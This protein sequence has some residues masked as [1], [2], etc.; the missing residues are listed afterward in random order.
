V[1]RDLRFRHLTRHFFDGLFDFGFLSDAGVRS[2]V[3]TILGIFA[4][5]AGF[6]LLLTR[7]FMKRYGSFAGADS[8]EPY[9]QAIVADHAFLIAIPMWIVAFVTTLV[10]YAL[11]PDETDF[12]ILM[13]LPLTR[14]IVFA[15]KLAAVALFTG[16]FVVAT[17]LALSPL[18]LLSSF[19][20]WAQRSWPVGAAAYLSASLIGSM[21]AL[22]LVV[23]IHGVLVLL[24]IRG[25][26]VAASALVRSGML[27]ALVLALPFLLRLPMQASR[28]ADGASFLSFIPPAWF[29]G[30]EHTLAGDATPF[31]SGLSTIAVVATALVT[32]IAVTSY[33]MLYRHF[34]RVMVRPALSQA[35]SLR[36]DRRALS[37][38]HLSG[39]PIF[40]AIR[41]FVAITLRRS[42]FHQG[43]VV[44]ISALGGGLVLNSF[45][46]ADLFGWMGTGGPPSQRLRDAVIWAPLAL[47]FVACFAVRASLRVPRELRANWVFRM[48]EKETARTDQLGPATQTMRL[49]GV[50]APV[51]LLLPLQWLVI[52]PPAIGSSIG[53][54]V[55]GVLL[56]ELLMSGWE[57]IPFTAAYSPGGG[58]VPQTI[59]VGGFSFV[60]FTTFGTTFGATLAQ[61]STTGRPAAAVLTVIVAAVIVLLARRRRRRWR[62][63]ELVF[64]EQLPSEIN[65]LRLN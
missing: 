5:L 11:F 51:L 17:E 42:V 27:C 13:G 52:G 15:A 20:S 58:F 48:T 34:D 32:A 47:I 35:S 26:M 37:V 28:F 10:G 1:I 16:I 2:F 53:A 19:S 49:F 23:A 21:F 44:A 57:R 55:S 60:L 50:I 22:L 29:V 62:H 40:R 14:R 54:A 8:P 59:L 18:F 63:T 6:G 45:L 65:P 56:V 61:V 43:I 39:R 4:A 12:R 7:V 41:T 31:L 36:R 25:R 3:R 64:D 9:L 30:L 24:A 33:A 46:N 38:P